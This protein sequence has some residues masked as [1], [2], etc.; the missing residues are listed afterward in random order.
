[1][2]IAGLV[3]LNIVGMAA[4][5][6]A[7][8]AHM[9]DGDSTGK[10]RHTVAFKFKS[11]ASKEDI[12]KVVE[13]FAALKKKIPTILSFEWGTNMSPENRNKGF[14]HAFVLTFNSEKDRDAYL[15]DPAHKEFG[16]VVGPV[17]EDV[18][19]IDFWAHSEA[20]RTH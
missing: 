18:F 9:A 11:T 10:L 1:M 17:L 20:R 6:S 14:T 13:A 5:H 7:G 4:E 3:A 8:A 16:K 19:V 15:I 2:I 12:Q